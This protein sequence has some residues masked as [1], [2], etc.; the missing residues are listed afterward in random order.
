MYKQNPNGV[1]RVKR[2]GPEQ[3]NSLLTGVFN[4]LKRIQGQIR[5]QG[6]NGPCKLESFRPVSQNFH[7]TF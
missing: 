2:R 6:L 7:P 5:T 3:Y 1:E 4:V